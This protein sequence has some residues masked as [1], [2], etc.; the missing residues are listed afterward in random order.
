[1]KGI[2]RYR[3]WAAYLALVLATLYAHAC[4]VENDQQAEPTTTATRSA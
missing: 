3:G 4:A 2:G 1:M